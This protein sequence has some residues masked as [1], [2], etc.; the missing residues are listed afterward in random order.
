[1]PGFGIV[2]EELG[3]AADTV[4]GRIDERQDRLA[5][6]CRVKGVPS[7]AQDVFSGARASGFME[8]TAACV[9]RITGRIVPPVVALPDQIGRAVRCVS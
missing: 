1:L 3:I 9:P 7:G 5:G 4:R 8:E 2:D 6:N